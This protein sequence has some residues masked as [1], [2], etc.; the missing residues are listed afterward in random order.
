M[1]LSRGYTDKSLLVIYISLNY[2]MSVMLF[3]VSIEKVLNDRLMNIYTIT[4]ELGHTFSCPRHDF[5]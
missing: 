4:P 1:R 5:H 2:L 3:K